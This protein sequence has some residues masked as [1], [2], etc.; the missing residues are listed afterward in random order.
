MD[1]WE[2]LSEGRPFDELVDRVPD[3][4]FGWISKIKN[5][6]TS[7]YDAIVAESENIF[8]GLD[9]D[10]YPNRKA[11]AEYF[12]TQRYRAILFAM[13]D[14]KPYAPIIW[15]LLKPQYAKPYKIER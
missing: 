6:L 9:H 8:N 2:H 7:Q 14:G 15:K 13:L 5:D 11:L 1:I 10:S 4:F 3:E 12:K